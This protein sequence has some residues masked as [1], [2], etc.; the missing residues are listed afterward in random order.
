MSAEDQAEILTGVL[1]KRVRTSSIRAEDYRKLLRDSGMA[2][3]EADGMMEINE[4][5]SENKMENV[6]LHLK[7]LLGRNPSAF[8]DFVEYYRSEFQ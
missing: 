2:E 5:I 3:W 1:G 7:H 6:S 4:L 8:D